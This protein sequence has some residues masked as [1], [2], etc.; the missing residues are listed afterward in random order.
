MVNYPSIPI[1]SANFKIKGFREVETLLVAI[2][3][4]KKNNLQVSRRNE[5]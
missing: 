5:R 1:E 4:K 2:K 3:L